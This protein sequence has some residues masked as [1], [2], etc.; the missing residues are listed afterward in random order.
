MSEIGEILK[1]MDATLSAKVTAAQEEA[2]RLLGEWDEIKALRVA[3]QR[4]VEDLEKTYNVA[5][6]HASRIA[7]EYQRLDDMRERAA[8]AMALQPPESPVAP[9]RAIQAIKDVP[10]LVEELDAVSVP[11]KAIAVVSGVYFLLDGKDVVYVGQSIGVIYRVHQHIT[12]GVKKFTRWC[13]V[14]VPKNKLDEVE[15]FYITLLR[16]K[17]NK[18]GLPR[19]VVDNVDL[20]EAA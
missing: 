18:A 5:A 4:K 16:P 2:S 3:I 11:A 8:N 9:K 6:Q 19:L 10:R 17:Y 13:Y 15:R 1:K 12:E 7:S 20:Q 14:S